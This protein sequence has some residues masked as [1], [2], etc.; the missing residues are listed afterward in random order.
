[1]YRSVLTQAGFVR[2]ANEH[3][4]VL[5]AHNELGHDPV[6]NENATGDEAHRCPLYPT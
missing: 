3:L 2:W 5:V 4:V 6:V 1:M